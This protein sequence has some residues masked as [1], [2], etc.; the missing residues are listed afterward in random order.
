MAAVSTISTM[1]VERPRARSS[2]AP[3]RE[4]SLSTT[5]MRA[6]SAGT[7]EPIWAITAISA[8]WRRNV[9]LPAMCERAV[10][11]RPAVAALD[12]ELGEPLG[13]VERGQR[14]GGTRDILRP[15]DDIGAEVLEVRLLERERLVR[16]AVDLGLELAQLHGRVADGAGER[17]AVDE[18]LAQRFGPLRRHLDVVAEHVVVAHL[19]GG[20]AG[21]ATVAGLQP[22]DQAPTVIAELHHLVERLVIAA[23]DDAAVPDAGRWA[24]DKGAGEAIDQ[25]LVMAE[26]L[27]RG[28]ERRRRRLQPAGGIGAESI[29]DRRDLAECVTH[30]SKVARS[31]PPE[32]EPRERALHVGATAQPLPEAGPRTFR[33]DQEAHGIEARGDG[34]GVGERRGQPRPEQP[35][36]RA[37]HG[38]VDDREQATGGC[39]FQRRRELQVAP[40]RGVD[41]HRRAGFRRAQPC[42]P[43]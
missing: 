20:H 16:C 35:G 12:G 1:K 40:G 21:L 13:H 42:K 15:A 23:R 30:R 3:T 31:A 36:A 37:G 11:D 32:A 28:R 18:G 39:A 8:F 6:A 34:V 4:N 10:D 43:G 22:A 2:P 33:L 9:L 19:E 14:A 25:G 38:P 7:K 26:R 5:P 29:A 24:L 41:R 27:E 17:L